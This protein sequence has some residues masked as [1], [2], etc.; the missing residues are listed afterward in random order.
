[1]ALE[2]ELETYMKHLADWTE[3]EGKY[4][5]IK[6]EEVCGF[7]SSFDDVLHVGYDKFQLEPFFVKEVHQDEQVHRL[8]RPLKPCHTLPAQ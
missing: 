2:Q 8:S 3:H 1:M 7:Y 6:G 4:V 5:L